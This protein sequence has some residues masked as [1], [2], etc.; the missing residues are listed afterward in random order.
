MEHVKFVAREGHA[1]RVDD[2]SASKKSA[3]RPRASFASRCEYA[4]RESREMLANLGM[5]QSMNRAGDCYDNAMM[6]SLWS[7]LKK[8][9]VHGTRFKTREDA[10]LAIFEFC[11]ILDPTPW[12]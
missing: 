2:G 4:C 1:R 9:L 7:I 3:A 6:E 11:T 12:L 8:E 10:K 5:D